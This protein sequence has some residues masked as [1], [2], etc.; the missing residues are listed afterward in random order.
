L[1]P[2]PPKIII[3]EFLFCSFAGTCGASFFSPSSLEI[4]IHE[5]LLSSFAYTTKPLGI[6]VSIV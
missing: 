4:N 2:S 5:F 1:S 6:F 3:Q